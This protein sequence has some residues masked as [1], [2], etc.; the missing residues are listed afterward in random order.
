MH[1]TTVEKIIT[2]K[3]AET[4]NRLIGKENVLY[5]TEDRICYAYD[6]SKQRYIPDIVLQPRSAQHVSNILEFANKHEIPVCP[7]GA[8]SGLTG[9]AIPVKGGIVLDFSKMNQLI[10]IIPEDLTDRKSTRLNSSHSQISYA[11]F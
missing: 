1:T 3:L 11:V 2:S 6:G 8:G 9:G 7:R 4:F 5:K 10:E